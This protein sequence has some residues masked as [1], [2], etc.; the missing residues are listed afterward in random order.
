M[1]KDHVCLKKG[2]EKV[3]TSDWS[4]E[5][6]PNPKGKCLPIPLKGG[7]K[8]IH[9]NATPNSQYECQPPTG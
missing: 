9:K 5:E 3:R 2:V 4:L 8:A 1:Q 7:A 6:I